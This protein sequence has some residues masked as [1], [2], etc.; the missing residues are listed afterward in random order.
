LIGT[1]AKAVSFGV[2]PLTLEL[3]AVGLQIRG[4]AVAG[5]A[6]ARLY[7]FG[8]VALAVRL[9]IQH[10]AWSDFSQVVNE[11]NEALGLTAT[12][13]VWCDLLSQTR[14][15]IGEAFRRPATKLLQEDYLITVVNEFDETISVDAF[16]E[17][18]DLIPILS[19]RDR[20]LSVSARTDLLRNRFSYYPDD[21]AVITWDRAFLYEPRS[22]TDVADVL[23]MANAQLLELRAYDMLDDEFAANAGHD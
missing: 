5:A 13:E 12:T 15:T 16:L 14:D 20:P 8:I 2:P 3:G 4:K 10:L 19:G 23:E 21:L 6:T 7:D 22:E 9:P 18:V 1:P 17:R 11:T